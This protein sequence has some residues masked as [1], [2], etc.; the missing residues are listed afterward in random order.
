MQ[1]DM[2]DKLVKPSTDLGFTSLPPS[3]Y[4][5]DLFLPT[6][7][8]S[9]VLTPKPKQ[10]MLEELQPLF[11]VSGSSPLVSLSNLVLGQ[12]FLSLE[13]IFRLMSLPTTAARVQSLLWELR[14]HIKQLHAA[15]KT[16]QNKKNN[17]YQFRVTNFMEITSLLPLKH[18]MG[19]ATILFI[20]SD[21]TMG[22]KRSYIPQIHT[23]IELQN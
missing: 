23:S 14:S 7:G 19:L 1:F 16:K 4:A 18:L 8:L 11:H 2:Q 6:F 9:P 22:F 17:C 13:E 3:Q 12:S 10:K 21:C 20:L 15:A 5:W